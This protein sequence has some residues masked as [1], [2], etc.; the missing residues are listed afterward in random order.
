MAPSSG[1]ADRIGTAMKA[2]RTLGYVLFLEEALDI[3]PI[4]HVALAA[5]WIE[6]QPA[7]VGSYL[8]SSK[9][10]PEAAEAGLASLRAIVKRDALR[11]AR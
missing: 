6:G 8:C 1:D 4:M 10:A 7:A 9:S 3:E 2:A 11:P 5:P